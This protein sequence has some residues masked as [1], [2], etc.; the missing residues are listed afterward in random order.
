MG[1]W[2]G[3]DNG[4]FDRQFSW[5]KRS[6]NKTATKTFQKYTMSYL[7]WTTQTRTGYSSQQLMDMCS[8][9]QPMDAAS[10]KEDHKLPYTSSLNK[11][12]LK[13]FTRY[14]QNQNRVKLEVN[15]KRNCSNL[16]HRETHKIQQSDLEWH[17]TNQ[18]GNQAKLKNTIF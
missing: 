6:S 5:M 15:H 17:W 14:Y 8:A 16:T 2:I 11:V 3:L 10:A 1:K 7:R 12:E 9:Q 18:G 13:E 4:H